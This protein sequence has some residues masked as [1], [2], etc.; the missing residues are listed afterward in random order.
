MLRKVTRFCLIA[1][2]ATCLSTHVMAEGPEVKV[3]GEVEV[4]LAQ[5]TEKDGP[6]IMDM[7]STAKVVVSAGIK[8]GALTT[9][10]AADFEITQD[11]F[12]PLNR[13]VTVENDALSFAMGNFE[14]D[15]DDIS[16]G[17]DYL[18]F[19]DETI[20]GFGAN[21]LED[22]VG[23][24]GGDFLKL[25]LKETGLM[26]IAG[27]NNLDDSGSKYTETALGAY[28][29]GEFGDLSLGA[30]VLSTSEKIDE[31]QTGAVKSGPHDGGSKSEV[32]VAVGYKLGEMAFALNVDQYNKKSGTAGAKDNKQMVMELAFDLGLGDDSGIS[33]SYGT[34]S[35]DDGSSNKTQSTAINLGYA[36][37][38]GGAKLT[39]GY[40]ATTEKDDDPPKT[41][42]STSKV[43]AGLIFEF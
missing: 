2:A 31:K 7:S 39:V 24:K 13:S 17:N 10:G 3:G 22:G 43:G 9:T 29:G 11:G 8:T 14:Y 42:K 41:D 4:G 36:R 19:V 21:A 25:S 26:F 38:V 37:P 15:A 33:V 5:T 27:I 35:L 40:A 1:A 16:K 34:K 20:A 6:T 28:Y 30:A 18:S 23:Q 32:A 12:T